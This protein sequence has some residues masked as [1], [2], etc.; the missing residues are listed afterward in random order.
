MD[1]GKAMM[2]GWKGVWRWMVR[3]QR[4]SSKQR[5]VLYRQIY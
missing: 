2:N 3:E 5:T 1:G 4:Q